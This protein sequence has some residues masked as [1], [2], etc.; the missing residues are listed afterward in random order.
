MGALLCAICVAKMAQMCTANSRTTQHQA[1]PHSPAA[2]PLAH[3]APLRPATHQP[4]LVLA[5]VIVRVGNVGNPACNI[6][7]PSVRD[8]EQVMLAYCVSLWSVRQT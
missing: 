6:E 2:W 4:D 8:S 5:L 3:Q 1:Q 7:T